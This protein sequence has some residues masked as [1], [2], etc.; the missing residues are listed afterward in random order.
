MVEENTNINKLICNLLIIFKQY[1]R[2]WTW[3]NEF[4]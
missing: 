3:A 1:R 4:N 2:I